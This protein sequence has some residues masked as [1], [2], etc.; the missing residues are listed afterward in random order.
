MYADNMTDSMKA[1]IDETHRRRKIQDEYNK[2]H[3]IIPKT[4]IKPVAD[5]IEITGKTKEE[6]KA[7]GDIKQQI[8]LLEEEMLRLAKNLEFEKAA[9]I[10]DTLKVLYGENE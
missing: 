8:R 4:I 9:K 10:R 5:L 2:K 6:I 1:A 7:D 3:G